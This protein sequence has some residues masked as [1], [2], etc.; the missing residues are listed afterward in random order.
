MP[1]PSHLREA[2]PTGIVKIGDIFSCCVITTLQNTPELTTYKTIPERYLD[3][4]ANETE[5][6]TNTK[7]TKL[8]WK[9]MDDN[10]KL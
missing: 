4:E 5:E 7:K 9:E 6:K 8:N 10:S 3:Q 2:K 1:D